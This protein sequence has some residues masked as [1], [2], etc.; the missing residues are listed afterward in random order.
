VADE[1]LTVWVRGQ[2]QGVGFRWWVRSKALELGLCGSAG[3]LDDGRVEVIVEGP[4]PD[5]EALLAAL[6]CGPG[7]PAGITQRWAEARGS[8]SG[9]EV[10]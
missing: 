8:L 9:F 6:P 4:R 3:N 10:K 7:R 1:R 5:C 2:V